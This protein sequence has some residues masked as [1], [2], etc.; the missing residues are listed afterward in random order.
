M[1]IRSR[2]KSKIKSILFGTSTPASTSTGYGGV[3]EPSFVPPSVNTEATHVA[4]GTASSTSNEV[5]ESPET[6]SQ[7]TVV[8]PDGETTAPTN[9]AA[10]ETAG[11]TSKESK[12]SL[13]SEPEAVDTTGASFIVEVSELFPSNC[14]HCEATSHNNWIRIENKFACGSCEEAY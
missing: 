13:S 5:S 8:Q 9:E 7:N 10:T 11:T 14:P 6:H 2:I 12:T 1:A 3:T 4:T